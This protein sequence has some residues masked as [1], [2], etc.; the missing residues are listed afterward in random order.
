GAGP[1]IFGQSEKQYIQA[2]KDQLDTL[3][4]LVTGA[5][6]TPMEIELAEKFV[7]YVPCAEKVR[8]CLSGTEAV[9]LAIRL[10]RAYTKRPYFIRFEGHY[11]GWLDNV[12]GG[13]VD[14]KAAERPHA[15]ESEDDLLYTEGKSPWALK[16]SFKIPWNDIEIFEEVL[17]K[18][19]EEVAMVHMEPILV[20]TGCCHPRPNYLERVRELCTKYGI[21]LSFDEVIT[22]FRVGIN[23]AQG[24]LGVTPDLATFGKAMAAGLPIGAV[25]GKKEILDLLLNRKAI[26]LSTFNGYPLGTAASL[27]SIRILERDNFAFYKKIDKIQKRLMDGLREISEK[28]GVP[29]LIQGPRG[30]FF[31]QFVDKEVAWSV[32]DLAQADLDKQRRF[33]TLLADEGVLIMWNGRWYVSGAL[34][35]KDVDRTLDSVSRVMGRL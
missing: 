23:S 5:A 14:D 28:F 9:Q 27:A 24:L 3:Y 26:G 11:H 19:G 2:L 31:Y 13:M 8:F 6:Q 4:Y 18:Y 15:V 30:V 17:E 32:R 7:Q 35:E 16:E 25:A 34:T 29:T 20:N 1:G 33:R 21:V 22:G 12:I 10:A